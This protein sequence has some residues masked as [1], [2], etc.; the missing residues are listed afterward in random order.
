MVTSIWRKILLEWYYV[1]CNVEFHMSIK[2]RISEKHFHTKNKT[3]MFM[4]F[5]IILVPQVRQYLN[6]ISIFFP[7]MLLQK[8]L[9][10]LRTMKY[11]YR[12]KVDFET[13]NEKFGIVK[14]CGFFSGMK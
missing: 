9:S 2:L 8:R 13:L 6:V 12:M 10:F 3:Q 1:I 7:D 11:I 14:L 4:D 5:E